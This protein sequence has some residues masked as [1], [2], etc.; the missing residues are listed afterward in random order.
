MISDAFC[1]ILGADFLENYETTLDLKNKLE[2]QN[3]F[4]VEAYTMHAVGENLNTAK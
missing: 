1:S 2:D 3:K 4:E